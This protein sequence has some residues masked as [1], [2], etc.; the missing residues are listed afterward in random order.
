MRNLLIT[1]IGKYNHFNIWTGGERDFDVAIINYDSHDISQEFL[2][3]CVWYGQFP[4]FKYPGIQSMLNDDVSLL[5]YDYYWMPDEDIELSCNEINKMFG[6]MKTLNFD[7]AQPSIE[8]S[9]TSFPSW[10]IFIH[11]DNSD[12]ILTN[13]VEIM[14]PLFSRNALYKCLHTF[15]K[16]QSGWG[17]DLIWPSLIGDRKDNIAVLNSTI[18]R[19]TRPVSGGELYS[20]LANKKVHPPSERRN[21]MR[22]YGVATINIKRYGHMF[23]DNNL[24]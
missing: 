3:K 22:E 1:T 15:G 2:D 10:D 5:K 20:S 17:L 6:K 12:I 13:F 8:K 16:S 11:R 24:Q 7:L 14:C 4:T 18:A 23:S 21:I 9:S 19:H